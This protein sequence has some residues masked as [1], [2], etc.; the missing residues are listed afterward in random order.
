MKVKAKKHL[1][2]HFLKDKGICKKIADQ[3]KSHKGC[4]V[5]IEIG[6]GMG[7]LTEFLMEKKNTEWWTLDV[8]DESIGYLKEHYPQLGERIV[9][10]DFLKIDPLQ[11][12]GNR[13]FAVVGNFPY[14]ISSQILFRCIEYK[15]HIP[16][17]M[18]M[19]QREV[20]QRVAEKPGTKTYGILSVL[21]QAFYKKEYLFT[22]H[23]QVFTPPPKVKSAV[24]RLTRNAIQN[25][26]CNEELFFKVVKASFNQRRKTVRN[27]VK[28]MVGNHLV[29]SIYLDKRAEQLSVD[30][31]VQLT[32]AIEKAL[33]V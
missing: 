5:A 29:D 26:D 31:F 1:G 32:N 16:E 23:E 12:V 15:D 13:Q 33:K 4:E 22:V 6:P 10:G 3:Y 30:E 25:L 11:L 7:A 27:S 19:F 2:Q 9:H 8:D 24:I 28:S 18:G 17:I 20:A 21:L 14:N